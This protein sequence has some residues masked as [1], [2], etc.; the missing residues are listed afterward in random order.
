MTNKVSSF[1]SDAIIAGISQLRSKFNQ[2]TVCQERLVGVLTVALMPSSTRNNA[3]I[4]LLP[5]CLILFNWPGEQQP[6]VC[7]SKYLDSDKCNV[8]FFFMTLMTLAVVCLKARIAACPETTRR[9]R[10][11]GQRRCSERRKVQLYIYS[12]RNTRLNH[13]KEAFEEL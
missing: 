11:R 6:R 7:D 8:F 12:L 9:Q 10:Q 13:R 3:V 1:M 4:G 5:H 2:H